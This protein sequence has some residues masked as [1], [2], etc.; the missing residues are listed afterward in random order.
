MISVETYILYVAP[1]LLF[2]AGLLIYGA[3]RI[4]MWWTD[5]NT[6]GD[7]TGLGHGAHLG[8]APQP[9]WSAQAQPQRGRA[10]HH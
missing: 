1:L 7:D 2:S 4:T 3:F 10:A 8:G 6:S 9:F 5:R